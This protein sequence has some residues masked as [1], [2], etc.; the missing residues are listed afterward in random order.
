MKYLVRSYRRGHEGGGAV[1][2][3]EDI[4]DA[5]AIARASINVFDEGA[6]VYLLGDPVIVAVETTTTVR[7]P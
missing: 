7:L 2:D 1:V 6:A 3:A 5:V 4:E